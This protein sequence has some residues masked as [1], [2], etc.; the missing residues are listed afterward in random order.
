MLALCAFSGVPAWESVI[1]PGSAEA[2]QIEHILAEEKERPFG[3]ES[4]LIQLEG[5]QVRDRT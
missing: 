5:K 1:V 4:S 2:L 3:F